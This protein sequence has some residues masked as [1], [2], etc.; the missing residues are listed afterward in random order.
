VIPLPVD[1]ARYVTGVEFRPGNAQVVHHANMRIDRTPASR[2][3][4]AL[5]PAPGYDGW[6]ARTAVCPDGHFLGW[7]PGQVAP[8]LRRISH[9]VS[10]GH[11]PSFSCTCMSGKPE[12]VQ[13]TIG[14]TSAAASRAN[15]GDAP[16]RQLGPT[17]VGKTTHRLDSYSPDVEVLF[18]HTR[19]TARG[20]RRG[21]ASG[22]NPEA[23]DF[24]RIDFRWQHVYRFVTLSL[25]QRPTITMRFTYDNS[26]ENPRNPQ[27]PPGRFAGGKGF[28]RR[29]GTPG[30]RC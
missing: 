17:S 14:P 24:I 12:S 26:S 25:P 27:L 22:R 3:L 10:I 6:M 13:P 21:P 23:V 11:D 18:N 28:V 15:A 30:C 19:T 9:G 1:V 4:D 29:M 8:F 7:T 2:Q 5:D 16:A 20:D